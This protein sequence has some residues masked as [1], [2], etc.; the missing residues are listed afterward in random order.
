MFLPEIAKEG[1]TAF[2]HEFGAIFTQMSQIT[3]GH[4]AKF[5]VK[6]GDLKLQKIYILR[7]IWASDRF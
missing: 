1:K 3:S 5:W 2:S 4:F 6:M 7:E